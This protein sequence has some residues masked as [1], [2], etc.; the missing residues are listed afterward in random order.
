MTIID[1]ITAEELPERIEQLGLSRK[2]RIRVA[3]E[4]IKEPPKK[5]KWKKLADRIH[6]EN[7]LNGMGEE[8]DRLSRK[9]RD[10]F[11]F[12]HDS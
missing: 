10:E 1:N 11:E 4:P 8:V 9:F 5:G 7:I 3:F 6:R 12:K 2:T